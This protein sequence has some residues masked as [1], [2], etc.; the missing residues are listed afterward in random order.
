MNGHF[1]DAV[2]SAR[3]IAVIGASD[4]PRSLGAT[5]F[6][7]LRE[8]G[9]SGE[10]F[11]VNPRHDEVQGGKSWPDITAVEAPI[12][13][14]IIATPAAVVPDVLHQCGEQ[15]V[16][17]AVVLSAGFGELGGAGKKL[18]ERM[19]EAAR[20][21]DLRVIGPNCLGIMRPSRG[22]N[23]TFSRSIAKPG[24]LAL[25]SQSGAICTAILDWAEGQGIGFSAVASTGNAADVDFGD[26]LDF[27]ALDPETRSILLYVEG[28]HN[29]RRFMSGL[30][31]AARMKPVIVIKSGRHAEGSRAAMSHTG[32]L[33]GADDVFDAALERAG[34][35]RATS[36]FGLFSAARILSSGYRANGNRLAIIT[37]AGG[38]AVMATDCAVDLGLSIAE[39]APG[40][41][42]Q[43][44]QF[45]PAHWSRSNPVD[46]IGDADPERYARALS[47]CME[48]A[49]VDAALVMLTPQA[50]TDIEG[51]ARSVTEQAAKTRKPL[52]ACWMGDRQVRAAREHFTQHQLPHFTTPE[53]AV[54]AFAYL[55]AYARNQRLLVQV[56]G[57]LTDRTPPD[58]KSA[59]LI[60]QGAL[61]EG[62]RSLGTL[63]AKAILSAFRIPV[64]NSVR[65]ETPG[66]ALVAA[67]TVGY[68]V[69]MKID[70]PD[71]THK[72]DVHGV[73]LNISSPEHVRNAFLHMV[74]EAGRRKPEAR[75]RGV[76]IERMHDSPYG[77]ELM[78]GV[79]RDPVFGPVISFGSG[80]TRVEIMRDRSVALPPLNR[81]IIHSMIARTRVAALLGEFRNMPAV[82]IKALER[83]L[84]RVS[85]M[86]CELPEIVEMDINP[87]IVDE[88]GL[89]AVD[90]RFAVDY[91][92]SE[93]MRYGHMAIHPYPADLVKRVQL[94]DGVNLTIRPIR[95]EDAE[96]EREFVRRLSP[97]SR[98][99]RFMQAVSE[100][101]QSMLVRFT[102]IDYDREMALIAVVEAESGDAAVGELQVGVARY[103]VNPDQAS[104]EFALTVADEW[105][106]RGIGW[107]LMHELME[108]A[109]LRGLRRIQGEVLAENSTMLSLMERLDFSVRTH[110]EDAGLRC[111]SRRLS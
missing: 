87:L 29:A 93:T 59:R 76:T 73:R 39:L 84:L 106:G 80:G 101:S 66:E 3:N 61:A 49:S 8:G 52:I 104:C 75:I 68:P 47:A 105:Q 72:S 82:D 103:T 69:A 27:L 34:V 30:R 83:V 60:V 11:A 41:I 23:A 98:Y 36:I 42:D 26:L 1:L 18:E 51:S 95:P 13:L 48:D 65:A 38:P 109:R 20:E 2:F 89:V 97:R 63:E 111:V 91:P 74:E 9:F 58:V 25:V 56:P 5:V 92:E 70:S 28:V 54:E 110:P 7:N 64:T 44:H 35:V 86:V 94:P 10:L 15:G 19:A 37:N 22:I 107:Q 99:F 108:V 102:Q 17:C 12:D 90:A 24:N 88:R 31:S 96:I 14:A 53:S 79:I 16:K 45:L 32:A 4:R 67:G 6:A 46:L 81:V 78:V 50:M 57:P 43:L 21:H 62:R 77:R 100:L 85:E 33:V 55:A 40:T 71:I